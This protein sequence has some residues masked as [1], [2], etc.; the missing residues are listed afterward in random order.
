MILPFI[1]NDPQL[2]TEGGAFFMAVG[3]N[4]WF[5]SSLWTVKTYLSE[6]ELVWHISCLPSKEK[7]DPQPGMIQKPEELL[8]KAVDL[9]SDFLEPLIRISP[10]EVTQVVIRSILIPDIPK[11]PVTLLGDAAHAMTP[12]T[13]TSAQ[14]FLPSQRTCSLLILTAFQCN[15]MV[16]R[17]GRGSA[18][19]HAGRLQPGATDH[20]LNATETTRWGEKPRSDWLPPTC[21]RSMKARCCLVTDKLFWTVTERQ[22]SGCTSQ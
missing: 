16:L 22:C 2:T 15:G 11:G 1:E 4:K 5:F 18:A 12:R 9:V 21:W 7:H 8:P 19:R 6:A 14:I 3:S 17:Q 13:S 20:Q 10:D